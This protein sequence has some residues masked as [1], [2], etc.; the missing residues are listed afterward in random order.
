MDPQVMTVVA[1]LAGIGVLATVNALRREARRTARGVRTVGHAAGAV[2]RVLVTAGVIVAVQ[3]IVT[4]QFGGSVT[5]VA[6]ALGLPALFAGASLMRLTTTT[7][8]DDAEV[9][10]RRG[11]V[12]R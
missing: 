11:G 1:V 7:T 5:A 10:R 3:W 9:W 12:R 2:F 8:T 4:A 6:V